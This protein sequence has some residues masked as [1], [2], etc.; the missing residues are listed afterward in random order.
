VQLLSTATGSAQRD[1]WSHIP[2]S[3]GLR[4]AWL[5][6]LRFLSTAGLMLEGSPRKGLSF[7][8]LVIRCGSSVYYDR[9]RSRTRWIV[10]LIKHQGGG[11][12]RSPFAEGGMEKDAGSVKMEGRTCCGS[13]ARTGHGGSWSVRG[14]RRG[15]E[16]ESRLQPTQPATLPSPPLL[17]PSLPFLPSSVFVAYYYSSR[18]F[19]CCA[20]ADIAT[21][22]I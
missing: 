20:L 17:F 19:P 22:Q 15:T 11:G 9:Q 3:A 14:E 10:C 13:L 8:L 1:W 2:L 5:L 12:G 18:Y 7:V 6:F 21:T 4:N 16:G